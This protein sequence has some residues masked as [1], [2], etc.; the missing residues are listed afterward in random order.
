[1]RRRADASEPAELVLSN[2]SSSGGGVFHP[3]VTSD[4]S[5]LLFTH[6]L[7]ELGTEL[8]RIPLGGDLPL[9]LANAERL[10]E[11]DEPVYDPDSSPDDQYVVYRV[12]ESI[13]VSSIDG[14]GEVEITTDGR[15]PI[16]S[17]DGAWI[18]FL[19]DDQEIYRVA[20]TTEP[21]F[22]LL[23]TVERVFQT[24]TH[25]HFDIASDG[26]V[27]AAMPESASQEDESKVWVVLNL[28]DEAERIAPRNP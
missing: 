3:A 23:G 10:T 15:E 14:Q 8:H 11:A 20:V 4:G 2:T 6:N 21:V 1:M 12:G 13:L 7:E 19:R 24:Q 25:L 22:S 16:W 18:Y 26:S 17:P 27:L 28:A 5:Y 9:D